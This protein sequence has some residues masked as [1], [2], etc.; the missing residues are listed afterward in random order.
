MVF[1]SRI[2]RSAGLSDLCV[3]RWTGC[4]AWRGGRQVRSCRGRKG[5]EGGRQGK[6]PGD[7]GQHGGG[8]LRAQGV[9]VE[10]WRTG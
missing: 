5:G 6:R 1:G 2:W 9:L 7:L 3:G 10:G 4:R 8:D